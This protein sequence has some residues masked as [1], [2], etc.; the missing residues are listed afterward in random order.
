ME[1]D[2]L[3]VAQNSQNIKNVSTSF[4][5]PEERNENNRVD[6]FKDEDTGVIISYL[7]VKIIRDLLSRCYG[8]SQQKT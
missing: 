4:T 6:E 3:L 8:L 7:Q 2:T 1:T 5:V